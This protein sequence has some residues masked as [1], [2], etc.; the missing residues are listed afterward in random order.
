[1]ETSTRSLIWV[2]T[3]A[4]GGGEEKEAAG[5]TYKGLRGIPNKNW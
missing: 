3:S 1:M 2:R 4:P 5:N